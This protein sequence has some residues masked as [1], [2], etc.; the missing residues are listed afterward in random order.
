[1]SLLKE[2][3]LAAAQKFYK[4][5]VPLGLCMNAKVTRDSITL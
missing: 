2:F 1:M 4:Y 5:V 3:E